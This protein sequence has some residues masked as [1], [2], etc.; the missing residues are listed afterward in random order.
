[1]RVVSA[2]LHRRSNL[3][4]LIDELQ[5]ILQSEP[6]LFRAQL[7]REDIARLGKLAALARSPADPTEYRRADAVRELVGI[8]D[9]EAAAKHAADARVAE[10][11]SEFTRVR[12]ERLVGCL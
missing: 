6:S 11:W 12:L 5:T 7:L 2:R 4:H 9:H 8:G 10:A 1:M 3:L